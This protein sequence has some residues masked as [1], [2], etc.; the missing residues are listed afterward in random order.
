MCGYVHLTLQKRLKCQGCLEALK[1]LPTPR[2]PS[3]LSQWVDLTDYT[4]GAQIRV[5]LEFFEVCSGIVRIMWTVAH[6]LPTLGD[7]LHPKLVNHFIHNLN[8]FQLNTCHDVREN[9][10]S[11]Y[12]GMRLRQLSVNISAATK[13]NV[14]APYASRTM[15]ASHLADRLRINHTR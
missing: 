15:G 4:P 9:V 7:S 1:D 11:R 12:V 6:K 13:D 8:D 5:S 10:I 2:V 14:G 3:L